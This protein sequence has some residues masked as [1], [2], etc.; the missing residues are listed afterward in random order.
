[1][2]ATERILVIY[3]GGTIG[4]V[5]GPKG[6]RP[7][8]GF[9]QDYFTHELRNRYPDMPDYQLLELKPL[10]DSSQMQPDDWNRIGQL[11]IDH[12]ADYTGFLIIHG[13]DTLAYT[14]SALSFQLQNLDKPVVITGS[15]YSLA[16]PGSD[17]PDNLKHA[18]A[19][20][21][22]PAHH[23]V[24]VAF[25]GDLMPGSHV[26]K[27]DSLNRHAFIA[28][29]T[30]PI[31]GIPP[32]RKRHPEQISLITMEPQPISTF[33]FYPGSSVEDLA[34]M[35]DGPSKAIILRTFGSGNA[36]ISE[37][38]LSL[39]K[40][41]IDNGKLVVNISQCLRSEVDMQRYEVASQLRDI[42]VLSAQTMTYEALITKLMLL[43]S[44]Y[45]D[46]DQVAEQL[47]TQW[48]M[49]LPA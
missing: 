13:T 32:Y 40:T 38:L 18:L 15:M 47:L 45:P 33:T 5:P 3:T 31:Q 35:A 26:T 28:P 34:G 6:L 41:A 16:D 36:P 23:Q 12:Y 25:Q 1:V 7:Q 10:L 24:C 9:L 49:E 22:Q 29:I 44:H 8:S 46:R 48:A 20:V 39:V 19:Y 17:G 21:I 30:G 37:Q 14:A 4:M 2:S 42:G 43:F 27:M 11:V